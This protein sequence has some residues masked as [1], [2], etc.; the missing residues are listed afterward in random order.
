MDDRRRD[1]RRV[2]ARRTYPNTC[3]ESTPPA[4]ADGS[5]F[6][7]VVIPKSF[8]PAEP[9]DGAVPVE[10]CPC[11]RDPSHTAAAFNGGVVC[12]RCKLFFEE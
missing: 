5:G 9:G 4:V 8:E 7:Q 6:G 12:P 2:A 11:P 10:T 3:R 1:P